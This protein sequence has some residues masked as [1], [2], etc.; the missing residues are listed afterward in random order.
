MHSS[1]YHNF[2]ILCAGDL[3]VLSSSERR[4][5]SS[6]EPLNSRMEEK[7]PN[8]RH[9]VSRWSSFMRDVVVFLHQWDV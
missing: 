8:S 5:L 6:S 1:S 2:C 7:L 4:L 3:P 9:H